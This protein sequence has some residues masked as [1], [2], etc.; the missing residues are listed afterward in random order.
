MFDPYIV[1]YLQTFAYY[2]SSSSRTSQ[3]HL[4]LISKDKERM[5]DF[6]IV[7]F[8]VHFLMFALIFLIQYALID[9]TSYGDMYSC[10]SSYEELFIC[11][12]KIN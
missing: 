8:N 2:E 5:L 1:W 6:A 10:A 3:R 11:E 9:S 7:Q 12:E 4:I